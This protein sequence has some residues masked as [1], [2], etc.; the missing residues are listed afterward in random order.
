MAMYLCFKFC[1]FDRPILEE[2]VSQIEGAPLVSV[3]PTCSTK[4]LPP[5][6]S[7]MHPFESLA[8]I[9]AL[10]LHASLMDIHRNTSIRVMLEDD[11][12]FLRF[13]NSHSFLFGQGGKTM[14]GC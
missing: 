13:Q 1:I 2:N 9:S 6:L 7:E 5:G 3:I 8:I 14:V 10:D 4:C 11:F 12:I